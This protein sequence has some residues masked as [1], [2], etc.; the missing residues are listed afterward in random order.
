[1][2]TVPPLFGDSKRTQERI[3]LA[4]SI[5]VRSVKNPRKEFSVRIQYSEL[6][7]EYHQKAN[8]VTR[9]RK[10]RKRKKVTIRDP[11][12]DSGIEPTHNPNP[13]ATPNTPSHGLEQGPRPPRTSERPPSR[14]P[15]PT[16]PAEGFNPSQPKPLWPGLPV[17]L[18]AK[19]TSDTAPQSVAKQI[20]SVLGPSK[21]FF[22][23]DQDWIKKQPD[24]QTFARPP[25]FP[26]AINV[27]SGQSADMRLNIDVRDGN[28]L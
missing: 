19:R 27:L 2:S 22:K 23:H 13:P 20:R 25:Q 8:Y 21:T 4:L 28:R 7:L 24:F 1:M 5:L 9:S 18:R 15:N 16:C 6:N 3:D 10:T 12:V 11:P 17:Q 26:R 14:S